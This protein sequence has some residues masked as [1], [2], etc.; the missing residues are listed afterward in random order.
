MS[1][2][3]TFCANETLSVS[4]AAGASLSDATNLYGLRLYAIAM[5]SNWTTANL[6]FQGSADGGTTWTNMTDAY[7]NEISVTANVSSFIVLDLSQFSGLQ[8]LKIRSGSSASPIAQAAAR[9]L[10]LVLRSV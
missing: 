4:I 5:P 9:S 1:I 2:E 7:G 3:D 10:Q 6:T 8:Y